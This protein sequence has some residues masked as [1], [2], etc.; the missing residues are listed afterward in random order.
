M[1]K[2]SQA[3]VVVDI[4]KNRLYIFFDRHV[5][6]KDV[7]RI[8][9]DVR[10]GVADLKPGFSVIND[11]SNC[12]VGHLSAAVSFK[13]I[14][15]FLHENNVGRVVRV[16]GQT[17]LLFKQISKLSELITDYKPEYVS[18]IEEAEDTLASGG[19]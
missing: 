15:S 12:T 13:K 10:F 17:S 1:K 7:E 19:D 6:P 16:I 14:T 3:K 9:T 18:S 11:L 4:K 8:Y 2:K 5:T